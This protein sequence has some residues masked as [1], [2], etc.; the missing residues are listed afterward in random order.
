MMQK[1]RAA[2][3]FLIVET[4]TIVFRRLPAAVRRVRALLA[5]DHVSEE[6]LARQRGSYND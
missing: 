2:L 6:W 4:L 1:L 5:E 3:R